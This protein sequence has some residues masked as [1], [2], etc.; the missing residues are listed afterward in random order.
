MTNFEFLFYRAPE[1]RNRKGRGIGIYSSRR[2]ERFQ[3]DALSEEEEH[4]TS[5]K[6]QQ[7]RGGKKTET[8]T[9]IGGGGNFRA[10]FVS[11]VSSSLSANDGVAFAV[12]AVA[13]GVVTGGDT[14]ADAD[15]AGDRVPGT[16]LPD[17]SPRT[18][19]RGSGGAKAVRAASER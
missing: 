1:K 10:K 16:A 15:A 12:G 5:E 18:G 19:G 8:A 2:G 13:P 3:I 4:Q 7:T 11:T 14:D 17:A 9:P 6:F